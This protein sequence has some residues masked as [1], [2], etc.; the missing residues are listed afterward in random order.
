MLYCPARSPRRASRRLL[1]K[2]ARSWRA[3]ALSRPKTSAW[4]DGVRAGA[5]RRAWS[6]EPVDRRRSPGVQ[7]ALC[8]AEPGVADTSPRGSL[9]GRSMVPLGYLVVSRKL[10]LPQ[11]LGALEDPSD[12]AGVAKDPERE[13][14]APGLDLCRY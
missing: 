3:S 7:A 6:V 12:P 4:G 9:S 1:G 10:E 11:S 5:W 13:P 14:A 2:P 8:V